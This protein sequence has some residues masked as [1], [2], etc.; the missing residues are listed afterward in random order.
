L[1]IHAKMNTT[2]VY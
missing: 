1:S 2:L